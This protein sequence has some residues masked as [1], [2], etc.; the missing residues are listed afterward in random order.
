MSLFSTHE[1]FRATSFD[2]LIV[3]GGTSGLAVAARLSEDPDMIIGVIE[4][5]S[6]LL[7]DPS[8]LTQAAFPTLGGR[9]QY[10]WLMK[11][12]PSGTNGV[13]HAFP[14]HKALGSSSAINYVMYVRG[15]A[16]EYDDWARITG[17]DSWG[18]SGLQPY[19]LKHEGTI[20]QAQIHAKPE[21]YAVR[22][23]EDEFHGFSGPIKTSFG[24]WSAPVEEAWHKAGRKMG[25]QW[26][27]PKDA[28]S[29]SHLG[30]YSNLST[31]NRTQGSGIQSYAVNG[32][33][34]PNLS[35]RNLK[36]L[37]EATATKVALDQKSKIPVAKSVT[38][39]IGGEEVVVSA[40][41]EIILAAG[42]VQTPQLLELSGIG[43]HESL[44]S[45]GLQ[46]VVLNNNAGE[47]LVNHPL[48]ILSYELINEAFSL[49]ESPLANGI[50]GNAF[51]SLAQ[52][53]TSAELRNI[54]EIA[55]SAIDSAPD[56]WTRTG[57]L[58]LV[59]LPIT[60]DPSR[61]DDQIKLLAP[62]VGN[63]RCSVVV[64][65]S[66]LFSKGTIYVHSQDPIVPPHI[67]P[68]YLQRKVD[69]EIL[70]V[71]IRV[72]DEMFRT[73]PLADKVRS[74]VFAKADIDMADPGQRESYIWSDTGTEYH[75]CG[76]AFLGK[77]VDE[78]LMV[79]DASNIPSH[80]SGNLQAP[81]YAIAEQA[82]NLIRKDAKKT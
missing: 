38:L 44:Q 25:L 65:V 35:R 6:A 20:V 2:Y 8:I 24:N 72:A 16:T 46:C 78:N 27:P 17:Y 15:Q 10:D 66:H 5:G 12:V 43:R 31:I 57:R 32:Y 70:P 52:I 64:V 42:V 79:V 7:E 14:R 63:N 60:L 56:D 77:V 23:F 21:E 41:Q 19:F 81:V 75:P 67:D 26:T 74:R 22:A 45:A 59:L 1:D 55:R 58:Q 40:K 80:L 54:N 36:T 62:G 49:E 47:Q 68:H 18:W 39:V 82:A 29:G 73:K 71:G 11:T 61:F 4:A 28:W 53:V 37:M 33:I 69:V 9:P 51:L 76:T 30:G 13:V 50:N 34:I 48:T 3:A